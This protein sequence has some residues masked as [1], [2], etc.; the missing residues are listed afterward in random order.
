M[1][2]DCDHVDSGGT[3]I[4]G[5]GDAIAAN[6]EGSA[7]RI[8]LLRR[9]VDAHA[10]VCDGFALVNR[11][12]ISSNEDDCVGA[13][14]NA[15]DALSKATKFDCVGLAPEFFVLG[16]DKK[17]AHFHEGASVC[18]E[19]CVENFARE[20]PTRGLMRCEWAAG[21]VVVN[22]DTC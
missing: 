21:D 9:I 18:V 2:L 4:S 7:I 16:V 10:P 1:N 17:V 12:I 14:T 8:G 13:L 5:I 11:D 20:S 15:W 6:S 22:M 3:A 19:D